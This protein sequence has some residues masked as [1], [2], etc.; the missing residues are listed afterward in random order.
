MVAGSGAQLQTKARIKIAKP[1]AVSGAN[2]FALHPDAVIRGNGRSNWLL[3][4]PTLVS[5]SCAEKG[6]RLQSGRPS[7]VARME[8]L[9]R[10]SWQCQC[11]GIGAISGKHT[12]DTEPLRL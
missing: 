10:L 7:F 4:E 9:V 12:A 5:P 3:G 6:A 2:G 8:L 11:P 1:S